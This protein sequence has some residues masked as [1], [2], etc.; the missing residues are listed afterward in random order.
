M[1]ALEKSSTVLSVL[2]KTGPTD[3]KDFQGKDT[4][5]QRC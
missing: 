2:A 5:V 1:K 4:P 3:L